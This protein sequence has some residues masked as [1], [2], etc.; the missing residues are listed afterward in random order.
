MANGDFRDNLT[1]DIFMETLVNN[2]RND[3]VNYQI[4]VSRTIS[5]T[6]ASSLNRIKDLKLDYQRNHLEISQLERKLDLIQDNK[7]RSKLETNRNFEIM[8]SEKINPNL[9][10]SYQRFKI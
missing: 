7:L 10:K 4:F 8:N 9:F 6:V 5:D 2:L 3:C 1:D